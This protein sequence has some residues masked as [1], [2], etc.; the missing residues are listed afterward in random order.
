VASGRGS[1]SW[2][3]AALGVVV[4]AVAAAGV[5]VLASSGA[6]RQDPERAAAIKGARQVQK[7]VEGSFLVA[8][9]RP[10]AGMHGQSNTGH[11]CTHRTV[12]VRLVWARANF[13][14]AGISGASD[15]ALVVTVNTPS[16][17]PCLVAAQYGAAGADP[18]PGEIYLYG[19]DRDLVPG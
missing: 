1:R 14:H 19:P 9:Y 3:L 2:L 17:T 15:Q 12:E 16:G 5:H 10:D 6:A 7:G 18:K 11:R 13:S 8:T 4:I